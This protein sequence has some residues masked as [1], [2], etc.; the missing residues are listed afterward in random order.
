LRSSI[1]TRFPVSNPLQPNSEND[2]IIKLLQYIM[3]ERPPKVKNWR[4]Y[5]A[6]KG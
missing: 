3:S 1:A 4:A 5:P 2:K 6:K